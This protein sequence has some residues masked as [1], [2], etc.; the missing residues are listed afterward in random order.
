MLGDD[1]VALAKWSS[2]HDRA[3][4]EKKAKEEE[5][6]QA[7]APVGSLMFTDVERRI[8]VFVFRC[9]FAP[10][11]Y[12]ARRLVIHGDVLLNGRKVCRAVET[13]IAASESLIPF[14]FLAS[15]C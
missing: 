4:A 15:K 11:V 3:I 1:S 5:D 2:R 9:C 6:K 7:Q 12:E 10:S 13:A 8:D 14:C